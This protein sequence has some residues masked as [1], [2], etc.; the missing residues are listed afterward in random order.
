MTR[1]AETAAGAH[2]PDIAP[3]QT[4]QHTRGILCS[5]S[6]PLCDRSQREQYE[7]QQSQRESCRRRRFISFPPVR[8][9]DRDAPKEYFTTPSQPLRGRALG[10]ALQCGSAGYIQLNWL[11]LLTARRLENAR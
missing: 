6:R 2:G 9:G 11:A 3:L 1:D 8:H 10:R 5:S 4:R 7:S